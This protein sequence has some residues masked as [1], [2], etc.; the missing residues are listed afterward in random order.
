R[1]LG[2]SRE[3]SADGSAKSA[4]VLNFPGTLNPEPLRRLASQFATFATERGVKRVELVEGGG[5]LAIDGVLSGDEDAWRALAHDF[6]TDRVHASQFHPDV[7][8]LLYVKQLED[9]EPRLT[10]AAGS[11]YSYRDL[12]DTTDAIAKRLRRVPSVSKVTRS[13]I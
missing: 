13:G 8:K 10:A 3:A 6:L 5:F 4:V 1:A 9:L 12:D 2:K 7:W 11:E